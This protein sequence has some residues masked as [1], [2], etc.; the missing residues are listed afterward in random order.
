MNAFQ[1]D[2]MTSFKMENIPVLLFA[3]FFHYLFCWRQKNE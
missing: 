1:N 3:P 2:I